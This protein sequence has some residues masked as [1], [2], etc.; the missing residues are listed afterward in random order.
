[1]PW[2]FDKRTM[3]GGN[4][5]GGFSMTHT[6]MGKRCSTLRIQ[7]WKGTNLKEQLTNTYSDDLRHIPLQA[8]RDIPMVPLPTSIFSLA[9]PSFE[10]MRRVISKVR[11]RLGPGPNGVPYLLSNRCPKALHLLHSLVEKAWQSSR[12]D[13]EWKVAEGVYIPK[14]LAQPKPI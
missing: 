9:S 11:N 2:V 7:E 12:V 8:R 10:E 5:L 1:M 13:D 4:L 3:G 6:G 14:G